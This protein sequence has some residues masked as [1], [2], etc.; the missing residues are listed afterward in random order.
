MKHIIISAPPPPPPPRKKMNTK[1]WIE[2]VWLI[3]KYVYS[4]LVK[5]KAESEIHAM[6][7]LYLLES[8]I[9]LG[10]STLQFWTIVVQPFMSTSQRMLQRIE[11]LENT[12]M[13][14]CT[15]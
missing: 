3:A 12:K 5:V 13:K 1:I 14:T 8:Q 15:A 10:F 2:I 11:R 7:L 6:Y 4:Y 9:K